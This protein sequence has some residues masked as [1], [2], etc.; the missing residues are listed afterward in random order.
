MVKSVKMEF[1]SN[2]SIDAILAKKPS[3]NTNS[4]S[5]ATVIKTEALQQHHHLHQM[6]HHQYVHPYSNSDGE[7]SASED[8]DSPSR[9]ST[10]MSSAAES[11]SSQNNDKLDVEFDDELEDQLLEDE[12]DCE[13]GEGNPSKKQ[14]VSSG[15]DN[16]KPP[17]SYNALIMMAIQDSP[18][19]RLTLNGIYQY[20]INRFPYFKAN[21][22]GWQNSIRH[23][24]S[25]NK[26]FTKI[27]RSYDD[28]G[29]G[30][31]WILDP[32]AEEVFI[33]ETTGKLRRKNP[34]AS[35][36]RLAAYRQAIF[37]PMMAGGSPYGAPA[38]GYGYPGVPFAG[39]AAAAAA[40]A[41]ALYQR[42]NPAAYQAAAAAAAGYQQ[43]QYQAAP[44]AHPQSG[45]VSAPHPAQMQGYP[46]HLN[47]ELFQRMQFFGKF[48]SS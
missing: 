30:N 21:K 25:L 34:G 36:T 26:C 47:A 42:M 1:K 23:N 7:L 17:Y 6:P 12:Q 27:P 45:P 44:P 11:L 8:F 5:S 41:A 28:P 3:N 13:E 43:M 16:K 29:K 14:K 20:L 4:S 18:E 2:F 15:A 9:T 22:R 24:L 37:S 48:P 32:S 35:R 10:P 33:G 19:Q 46:P 39:A 38:P 31:Y 40:A